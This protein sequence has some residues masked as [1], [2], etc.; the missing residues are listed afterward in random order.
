LF[1]IE[2]A[3]GAAVAKE[4]NM[5]GIRTR[6]NAAWVIMIAGSVC[7][8]AGADL[9]EQPMDPPRGG[10][11][12]P[13][14]P[15]PMDNAAARLG[16]V[17]YP[18]RG[19]D[20]P[21][22]RW[23]NQDDR[24][25]KVVKHDLQLSPGEVV[26]TPSGRNMPLAI[27]DQW[28]VVPQAPSVFQEFNGSGING[29]TPADPDLGVGGGYVCQVV[30][31]DYLVYDKCGNLLFSRDAN[32]LFGYDTSYMIFD[33]KIAFDPWQSRWIML[34]HVKRD[35]DQYG[36][37]FLAITRSSVPFGLGS[38]TT[39]GWDYY[40]FN[41]VQDAGT[42]E[43]SAP[44]YYD[45]GYSDDHVYVGGDQFRFA[46]GFRWSRMGIWR[47]SEI[48]NFAGAVTVNHFNFNNPDGTAMRLPRAIK[49]QVA[50]STWD[51]AF[52]NSRRT[53]GNKLTRWVITDPFGTNT[54]TGADIDV[55][56]YSVP[57][58]CPQPSGASLDSIDCRLMPAVQCRNTDG[59]VVNIFTSLNDKYLWSGD[60]ANRT[61]CHFFAIGSNLAVNFDRVFGSGGLYYWFGSPA[62]DF[63]NSCFWVFSRSGPS[64]FANVRFVDYDQGV[65]SNSS[66]LISPGTGS[67]GTSGT[68]R[69]GDY[70]GA[71]IDWDDYYHNNTLQCRMWM[72]AM[73]AM[74]NSWGTSI[75]CSSGFTKGALAVEG[76]NLSAS[77]PQGGPFTPTS[78]T[79]TLTNGG[80][81][82]LRFTVADNATWLTENI[83][84]G[85]LYDTPDTQPIGV[86][87]VGSVANSL[88]VGVYTATVTFT[89]CSRNGA[90][91]TRPA[92]LTV[93]PRNDACANA[94]TIT[95][96]TFTG[97][98]TTA[99]SESGDL[100]S[101][102]LN[103]TLD[104]WYRY[105][106]ACDGTVTVTT[107]GGSTNFDTTLSV[108][109]ECGSREMVCNDDYV[110]CL[111][112][113]NFSRV[114]F[115]GAAGEDYYIRI[116]GYAG[117][118]GTYTL[119]V[120]NVVCDAD[121]NHDCQ[122][123]FFDY[124]DFVAA[125]ADE[126]ITADWNGDEQV[127]FFDYLDFASA[128]DACA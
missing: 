42:A 32:D 107:C 75:A 1:L 46:G 105:A 4:N 122:V 114:Q 2:A 64:E 40:P 43:A 74:P 5:S 86:S 98:T 112:N 23:G 24:V 44:D 88:T 61:V 102:G 73:Y 77:G 60:T 110:L 16:N 91:I 119:R 36:R 109:S 3:S 28:E 108:F 12:M 71:Q 35:S 111:P 62:A 26:F 115:E 20:N 17:T 89:D 6:A 99:S 103:D 55:S 127:D 18:V 21:P 116:A 83:T 14:P 120:T 128:F 126:D 58:A 76:T 90:V 41:W 84:E 72:T 48:Y 63:T 81:T 10:Q 79:Y 22:I 117:T 13:V 125:F 39:T 30:N 124:L 38:G 67:Y 54:R 31:D 69:W 37:L 106:A 78:T 68:Q 25:I 29:W 87:L 101:C 50:F 118:T 97:S 92:T 94:T 45:L 70:F 52:I 49:Q 123:D 7:G 104:V 19:M 33:C 85:E 53:G 47:K 96:G 59:S 27:R 80:Q 113:A 56:D 93:R 9:Q 121:F 82:G 66:T 15:A 100:S 95:T 8:A 65:F 11:A 51:A 34:W 57:L